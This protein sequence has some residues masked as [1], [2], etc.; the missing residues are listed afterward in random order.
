MA[1]KT[2]VLFLFFQKPSVELERKWRNPSVCQKFTESR[3]SSDFSSISDESSEDV[4]EDRDYSA[5]VEEDGGSNSD[6]S[7]STESERNSD[8][9][10][11]ETNASE[12]DYDENDYV[13]GDLLDSTSS[14]ENDD[15]DKQKCAQTLKIKR[16][17]VDI[18]HF[19]IISQRMK[20]ICLTRF[21]ND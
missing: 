6:N 20:T 14:S 12:G 15:L 9:D 2:I 16:H 11:Y 10:E 19:I 5:D 18:I 17:K 8:L 7:K 1:L 13:D 3:E 4:D 21:E